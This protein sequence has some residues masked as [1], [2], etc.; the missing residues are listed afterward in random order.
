MTDITD[1]EIVSR[2][3]I[4]APRQKVFR[5]WTE[6][7]HLAVWWGPAGFTNTF[8]EF[9]PRPGGEWRFIMHGPDGT[10]YPN[11]SKFVEVVAPELITFDHLL[12]PKFRVIATFSEH[13]E[14]T[15]VT[16]RMVFG[17]A[18]ECEKIK[19]FVVDAN[20]ENF[21]RLEAELVRMA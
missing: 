6:P 16:F 4:H 5:A 11:H 7:E 15:D 20:E 9:E 18:A 13:A 10:N 2:R 8:H 12:G 14:G 19:V 21:D 1:R 3:V 17:S